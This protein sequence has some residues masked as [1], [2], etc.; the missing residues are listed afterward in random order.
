MDGRRP[1]RQNLLSIG[2]KGKTMKNIYIDSKKRTVNNTGKFVLQINS[3]FGL[4]DTLEAARKVY[5]DIT[6]KWDSIDDSPY[7][8]VGILPPNYRDPEI[9]GFPREEQLLSELQAINIVDYAVKN[10]DRWAV[11]MGYRGGD[12]DKLAGKS[13]LPIR[14]GLYKAKKHKAAKKHDK[15]AVF[16]EIFEDDFTIT[17]WTLSAEQQQWLRAVPTANLDDYRFERRFDFF[18]E[19]HSEF[20]PTPKLP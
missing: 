7:G 4:F 19:W 10:P 6:S 9:P 2:A 17:E 8:C 15:N 3:V 16:T 12:I 13:A 20:L 1:A 18:D 5:D 14:L 11:R